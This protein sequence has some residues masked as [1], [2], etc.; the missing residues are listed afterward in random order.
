MGLS[1]DLFLL[2]T[3]HSDENKNRNLSFTFSG[4]TTSR[5]WNGLLDYMMDALMNDILA[6]VTICVIFQGDHCTGIRGGLG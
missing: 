6:F 3:I 4:S 1:Q 5:I 2:D